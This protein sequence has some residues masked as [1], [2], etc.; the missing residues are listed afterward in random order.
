MR[1]I[2]LIQSDESKPPINDPE[3]FAAMDR[4]NQELSAAGILEL[5]EGLKPTAHSKRVRF[6]GKRTTVVDGPFTESKELVAGF[7]IWKVKS[8]EEAVEW[9]K[10]IPAPADEAGGEG[11][12][13]IRPIW[14]ME[15]F[16]ATQTDSPPAEAANRK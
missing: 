10:R 16:L 6:G 3:F 15:D 7:W 5:A 2:V 9:V 8:M 14:S 4:F 1:V 13:E 11:Q 12:I